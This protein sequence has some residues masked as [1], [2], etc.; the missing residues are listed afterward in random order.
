M[1]SMFA[2]SSEVMKEDDL[3]SLCSLSFPSL[4]SLTLIS[5]LR[6]RAP[7]PPHPVRLAIM[8]SFTSS[9]LATTAPSAF[10]FSTSG[11]VFTPSMAAQVRPLLP[12]L[13]ATF[14]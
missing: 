8:L 4:Y 14:H 9:N 12:T 1:R 2:F 6:H 7:S 3:L 11:L 13:V 5:L 10:S